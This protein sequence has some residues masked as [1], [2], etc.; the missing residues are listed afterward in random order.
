M[1]YTESFVNEFS[2]MSKIQWDL[3]QRLSKF[4]GGVTRL[5]IGLS[6]TLPA[7]RIGDQLLRSATSAGANYEECHLCLRSDRSIQPSGFLQ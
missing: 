7:K 1:L 2:D 5:V 3:S 4:A 6:V